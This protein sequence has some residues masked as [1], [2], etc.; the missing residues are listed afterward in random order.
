MTA[1]LPP[2]AAAPSMVEMAY[3]N[4]EASGTPACRNSSAVVNVDILCAS[5]YNTCTATPPDLPDCI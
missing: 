5:V 3:D 1:G 2:T 4:G